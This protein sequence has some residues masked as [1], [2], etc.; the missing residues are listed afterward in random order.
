[1]HRHRRYKVHEFGRKSYAYITSGLG[2][3]K[4]RTHDFCHRVCMI[5]H[6]TEP[7]HQIVDQMKATD[8]ADPT[9]ARVYTLYM[10]KP[11]ANMQV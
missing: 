4:F 10:L 6:N 3:R 1:M 8:K 11:P 9:Y 7:Y 2:L 5:L